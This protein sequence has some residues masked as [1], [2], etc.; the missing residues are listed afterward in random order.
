MVCLQGGGGGVS[1]ERDEMSFVFLCRNI[2]MKSIILR[3]KKKEMLV[4]FNKIWNTLTRM[5]TL[6][7]FLSTLCSSLSSSFLSPPLLAYGKKPPFSL[8]PLTKV[9]RSKR[10]GIIIIVVVSP[11]SM[12]KEQ[13]KV[14]KE[15]QGGVL[16]AASNTKPGKR[17][18]PSCDAAPLQGQRKK[19][20]MF[21]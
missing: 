6:T 15:R 21:L 14:V 4:C 10:G 17:R 3:Q 16:G 12:E 9:G 13:S 7:F 19:E 2:G 20:R 1:V 18:E 8:V 5:F 11:R